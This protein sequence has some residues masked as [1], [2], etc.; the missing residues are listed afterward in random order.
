MQMDVFF[1]SQLLM[2]T[3]WVFADDLG[4]GNL[5]DLLV[6]QIGATQQE[7]EREWAK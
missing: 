7:R 4:L 3:P 6:N 5:N 1:L 2:E